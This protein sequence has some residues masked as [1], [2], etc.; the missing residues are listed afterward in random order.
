MSLG[1]ASKVGGS[2]DMVIIATSSDPN[3]PD[4]QQCQIRTKVNFVRSDDMTI[5]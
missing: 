4:K 1:E 2:E 5:Y 3:S